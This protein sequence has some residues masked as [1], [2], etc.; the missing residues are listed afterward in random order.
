MDIGRGC[1]YSD[2]HTEP[3]VRGTHF[4]NIGT[5]KVLLASY[6]C[7]RA[8]HAASIRKHTARRRCVASLWVTMGGSRRLAGTR[9]GCEEVHA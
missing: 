7:P 2:C 9:R 3:L 6:P 1:F 4:G 8:R 5:G